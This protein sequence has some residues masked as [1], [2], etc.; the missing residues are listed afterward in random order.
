VVLCPVKTGKRPSQGEDSNLPKEAEVKR[1]QV[2]W[3]KPE[4]AVHWKDE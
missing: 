2:P 4:R 3:A 1:G